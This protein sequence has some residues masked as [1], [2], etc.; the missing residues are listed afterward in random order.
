VL[1]LNNSPFMH[2]L[3]KLHHF[4]FSIPDNLLFEHL[5]IVASNPKSDDVVGDS[6]E[7]H[8]IHHIRRSYSS[9]VNLGKFETFAMYGTERTGLQ[10]KSLVP[11]ISRAG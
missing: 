6:T 5:A 10:G 7:H 2:R 11:N 1:E 8:P 9:I 3:D 4:C